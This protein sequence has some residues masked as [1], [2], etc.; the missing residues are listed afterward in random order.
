MTSTTWCLLVSG[1][2]LATSPSHTVWTPGLTTPS[3]QL[4]KIGVNM[5]SPCENRQSKLRFGEQSQVSS[6][7]TT[8]WLVFFFA[9]CRPPPAFH[10]GCTRSSSSWCP[11]AGKASSVVSVAR[12]SRLSQSWC[13]TS[14]PNT[15]LGCVFSMRSPQTW[16]S[17]KTKPHN[18]NCYN[19]S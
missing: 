5:V 6:P 14:S 7:V 19:C 3:G 1:A 18:E 15:P 8:V 4:R 12:S 11:M 2:S 9:S 10:T 13:V 17:T 16:A